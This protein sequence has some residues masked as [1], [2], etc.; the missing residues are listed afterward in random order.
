MYEN[1][2]QVREEKND[3]FNMTICYF[4]ENICLEISS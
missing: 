3:V 2:Y 1:K 4:A